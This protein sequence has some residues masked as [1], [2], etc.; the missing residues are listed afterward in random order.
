MK[1]LED[2]RM[3][4]DKFKGLWQRIVDIAE[5]LSIEPRKKRTVARQRHRANP[6]V[7]EIEAYYRVT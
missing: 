6:P 2:E 4:E 3:G 5:T 1:V 7:E